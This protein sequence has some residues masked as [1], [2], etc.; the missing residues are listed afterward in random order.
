MSGKSKLNIIINGI[1]PI[2]KI[3]IVGFERFT[4]MDKM[5]EVMHADFQ[6]I[7]T[8][9]REGSLEATGPALAVYKHFSDEAVHV[10]NAIEV[11]FNSK[12]DK[13]L[14][15]GMVFG[16]IPAQKFVLSVTLKGAYEGLFEAWKKGFKYVEENKLY[17][18]VY[19]SPWEVYEK[20]PTE[21]GD[22]SN[23]ITHIHIPVLTGGI[24]K[25]KIYE[26][27]NLIIS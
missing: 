17:Y 19:L 6:D 9:K 25:T 3:Y 2:D 21:D 23:C 7:F 13:L 10:I 8:N 24:V 18:D 16:V 4:T 15:Q 26:K 27:I 1:K 11:G 5:K 22:Y 14:Q 12:V 20:L